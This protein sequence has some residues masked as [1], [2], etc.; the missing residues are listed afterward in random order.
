MYF[1]IIL[2]QTICGNS[3]L[4]NIYWLK[5]VQTSRL[6]AVPNARS[7]EMPHYLLCLMHSA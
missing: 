7:A 2:K 5:P 4:I 1:N 6:T 3:T